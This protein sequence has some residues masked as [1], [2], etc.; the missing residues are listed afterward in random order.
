[1]DT[2]AQANRWN[3]EYFGSALSPEVLSVLTH[4]GVH[5]QSAFFERIFRRMHACGF[6]PRDFSPHL[7]LLMAKEVSAIIGVGKVSVRRDHHIAFDGTE[8]PGPPI[9]SSG[10]LAWFDRYLADNQWRCANTISTF[11]DVGCGF[12]PHTTRETAR[13]FSQMSLVG[14]DLHLPSF[15]VADDHDFAFYDERGEFL[16]L[17]PRDGKAASWAR[18]QREF[19]DRVAFFAGLVEEANGEPRRIG[20]GIPSIEVTTDLPVSFELPNL[21]LERGA[22]GAKLQHRFDCIRAA[23]V[24]VWFGPEFQC[25]AM[26]WVR[27]SL[28]P[29]GVFFRITNCGDGSQNRYSTYQLQ[30]DRLVLREFAFSLDNLR[31]VV[32]AATW[33]S[34]TEQEE[35]TDRLVELC[36]VLAANHDFRV[37]YNTVVDEFLAL[38]NVGRRDESGY[39]HVIPVEDDA[40]QATTSAGTVAANTTKVR[41]TLR[42]LDRLLVDQDLVAEAADVLRKHGY[43][44]R[45]NEA[46]HVGVLAWPR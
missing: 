38:N 27:E 11:L 18:T 25:Q 5:E 24:L 40:S 20:A 26:D 41:T 13:H 42:R 10:R 9:T 1:M 21:R 36:G 46:G 3:R 34:L 7:A 30:D 6:S 44:S 12:P 8:G 17:A 19:D 28:N 39:F 14:M 4:A 2:I 35:D 22:I 32:D 29:N 37:R 15:R 16:Y 45:V 31:P 43:E 23:T 33:S